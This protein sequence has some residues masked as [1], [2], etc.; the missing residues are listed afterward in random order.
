ML[1]CVCVRN[2]QRV[3]EM[4][5]SPHLPLLENGCTSASK[6]MYCS[7]KPLKERTP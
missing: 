3:G 4:D 1:P 2:R 5:S 6:N 7:V